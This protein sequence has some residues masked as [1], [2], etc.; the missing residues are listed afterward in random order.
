MDMTQQPSSDIR[1]YEEIHNRLMEFKRICKFIHEEQPKPWNLFKLF[2]RTT[3]ELTYSHILSYLLDPKQ[4]HGLG[5]AFLRAFANIIGLSSDLNY[6]MAE[7][8]TEVACGCIRADIVIDIEE[9]TVIIENKLYS[10]EGPEQTL[11]QEKSFRSDLQYRSR[12]IVF[13]FL[14]PSG[15]SA[16]NTNFIPIS[17]RDIATVLIHIS[18]NQI[19]NLTWETYTVLTSLLEQIEENICMNKKPWAEI[20]E[21]S[22]LYIEFAEEIQQVSSSFTKTVEN[23]QIGFSDL[24]EEVMPGGNWQKMIPRSKPSSY[25]QVYKPN[26]KTNDYFIHFELW[27]SIERLSKREITLVLDIEKPGGGPNLS[28][29]NKF[30]SDEEMQLKLN[31]IQ[32]EYRV[33]RR[34]A[35]AYKR[36]HLAEDLSDIGE[37]LTEALQEH[38]FLVQKIDNVIAGVSE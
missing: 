23:I 31:V 36:Y 27:C 3:D 6:S 13:V 10:I 21:R 33:S 22:K 25:V 14:T 28:F 26:W 38:S 29:C 24:A 9:L 30:D 12:S 19:R 7:V 35:I 32:S 37:T 2:R 16:I 20:T 8:Q 4:S 1:K 5:A 17:Y 18:L 34:H 11:A 15:R